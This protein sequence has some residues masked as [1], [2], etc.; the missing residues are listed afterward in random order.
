MNKTAIELI[1]QEREEQINKHGFTAQHDAGLYDEDV[2]GRIAEPSDLVVAAQASIY[3][4]RVIAGSAEEAELPCG[5]GP[6]FPGSW[7]D[8][9][10]VEK[11]CSKKYKDRLVI[12][13]A[14]LAAEID[15]LTAK[16]M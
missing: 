3:G 4:C 2:T 15:R 16:G 1:A 6:L 8:N 12:A 14:L 13:A 10:F 9:P 11:I 5:F 7:K